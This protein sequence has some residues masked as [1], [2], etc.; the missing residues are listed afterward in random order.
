M[1][2]AT[3]PASSASAWT[4]SGSA[5]ARA[6]ASTL[7]A[8]WKPNDLGGSIYMSV[9]PLA[10]GYLDDQAVTSSLVSGIYD[11]AGAGTRQ[12]TQA[13]TAAK[14][15]YGF[16][17][18]AGRPVMNF[19]GVDD[20]IGVE[21][22][23]AFPAEHDLWMLVDYRRPTS[24]AS[25][26]RVISYGNLASLGVEVRRT[27][28]SGVNR[29]QLAVGNGSSTI[30]CPNAVAD[31]SGL[32]LLRGKIRATNCELEI[33]QIAGTV[34]DVVPVTGTTRFRLGA[35]AGV[36][37]VAFAQCGIAGVWVTSVLS[38]TNETRMYAYLNTRKAG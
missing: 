1:A 13:T 5:S 35:A 19:D 36:S 22:N 34:T 21:G 24:N 14:P 33:N 37:P 27:V 7:D 4:L 17:G 16:N 25:V 31:F 30:M 12:L 6:Y 11:T 23:P 29:A 26:D 2:D 10:S 20:F 32:C 18:F 28:V 15:G 9:D 38:G 8:G 3:S